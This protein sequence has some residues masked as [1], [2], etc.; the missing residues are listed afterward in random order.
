MLRSASLV[1]LSVRKHSNF[2]KGFK[3]ISRLGHIFTDS[4]C[5]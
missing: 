5:H 4:F 3:G 2:V 1:R